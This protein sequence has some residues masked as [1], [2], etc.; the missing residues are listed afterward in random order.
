MKIKEEVLESV[1]PLSVFGKNSL[2]RSHVKEALDKY[3]KKVEELIDEWYKENSQSLNHK[4][5]FL[6]KQKLRGGE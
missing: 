5:I 1:L 2:V 6:L 3:E 4:N